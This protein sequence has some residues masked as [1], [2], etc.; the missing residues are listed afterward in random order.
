MSINVDWCFQSA[1]GSTH[2]P[3]FEQNEMRVWNKIE[4]KIITELPIAN[5]MRW[6]D[7][8]RNEIS[9]RSFLSRM[10]GLP[11]RQYNRLL[12]FSLNIYFSFPFHSNI[13]LYAASGWNAINCACW[14][15][16]S[17]CQRNISFTYS[18]SFSHRRYEACSIQCSLLS[19]VAVVSFKLALHLVFWCRFFLIG[20]VRW[21][22]WKCNS[23]QPHQWQWHYL[24]LAF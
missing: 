18:S 22:S 12:N 5:G 13:F 15:N 1:F 10:S 20:N 21:L 9:V 7:P 6:N 19:A 3:A 17:L 8:N 16:N 14:I 2:T 11:I 24:H 23:Q 4:W